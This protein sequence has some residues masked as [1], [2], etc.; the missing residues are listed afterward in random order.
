MLSFDTTGERG[1][2]CIL[3]QSKLSREL[4][5]LAYRRHILELQIEKAYPFLTG[6]ET[7]LFKRLKE[8]WKDIDLTDFAP[9]EG[10]LEDADITNLVS[11]CCNITSGGTAKG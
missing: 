6:P 11:L 5:N 9:L 2:T 10:V 3:T 7:L 4:R 1:G 8:C